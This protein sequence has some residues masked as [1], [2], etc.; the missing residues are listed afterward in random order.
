MFLSKQKQLLAI[1]NLIAGAISKWQLRKVTLL[2][3]GLFFFCISMIAQTTT[4][5]DFEYTFSGPNAIVKKYNGGGGVC[6]VPSEIT[7]NGLEYTV[8]KIGNRAFANATVTEIKLPETIE[9]IGVSSFTMCKS[10]TKINLPHG[11][12]EISGS[13]FWGC[14][15]LTQLIIPPSVNF[16][17]DSSSKSCFHNCLTL[18]TLI[19]LGTT[20]PQR[21]T[22]SGNTYVPDLSAYS[23]PYVTMNDARIIEMITFNENT[24]D[25]TG[26]A[27]KPTWTNN[28]AGWCANLDLSVIKADAGNYT[29]Y[30]PATFTKGTESFSTQIKYKYTINKGTITASVAN[31][32]RG[33]GDN[34]PTFNI[35]YSGFVNGDNESVITTKPIAITTATASSNVGTYPISVSGGVAQN[36][37]FKYELGT[38]TVTKAA[39]EISVNKVSKVYGSVN[40]TFTLNYSGLKNN[41]TSPS[42]E[43]SPTFSTT[44][45]NTSGVGDYPITVDCS[46]TN[47]NVTKNIPGTLTITPAILTV[48]ANNASRLYFDAEPEY[49][50][51]VT[52]FLNSDTEASFTKVPIF[53]TNATMASKVGTYTITPYGAESRNYDIKYE[54]GILTITKRQLTVTANVVSREYGENNPLFRISYDGFVNNENESMLDVIPSVT[55]TATPTSNVGTYT[56]SLSGGVATNYNLTLKSGILTVTKAPLAIVVNDATRKYGVF[57]PSFVATYSGLKNGETVPA[58]SVPPSFKTTA[59]IE[60]AVGTYPI[61]MVYGTPRNYEISEINKGTLSIIPADLT[62]KAK[63]ASKN[64]YEENPTFT[65]VCTGFVN[66]DN[67]SS[68]LQVQPTFTT[69]AN[70][71]SNVGTYEIVAK[72]ASSNNYNIVYTPGVLT[73]NKRQLVAKVG[74]FERNY[75][76]ENPSFTIEY[77]GFVGNDSERSLSIKPTAKT[78]ATSTSN[79]GTYPINVSGGEATNYKFSYT[80]GVLTVNKAEQSIDWNQDLSNVQVGSQIELTAVASSG[81]PI[82]YTMETNNSA[83]LYKVGTKTFIDCIASGQFLLKAIQNGNNNCYGTPKVTNTINIVGNTVADPTLTIIQGEKGLIKTQVAKGSVYTFTIEA[84]DGWKVHSVSFN[85]EDITEQLDA[86]NRFTTPKIN[87]STTLNVVYETSTDGICST[88]VSSAKILGTSYGI[89]VEN[90]KPN[91]VLKVYTI[92]GKL[93]KRQKLQSSE[94]DVD[95]PNNETYIINLED[96]RVKVRL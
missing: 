87:A 24:F 4:I 88:K 25:Y 59:T 93:V 39:L 8:T 82:E 32:S 92:D 31:V 58:W 63:D 21:W 49:T 62:I 15:N 69:T 51:A 10:M 77:E 67:A 83:S 28:V 91:E 71:K 53:K 50:Y 38:L 3:V 95:L 79:V 72:D 54:T 13:A 6:S 64:Y 41:E 14:Y 29:T 1:R 7:Y 96:I 33:Y 90:A 85:D 65:Y 37:T 89:K 9:Y 78:S 73:V 55:S 74:N 57:N 35:S 56:I 68:A 40:P 27:P 81:L 23:T 42:W 36:Y 11:L 45:D 86:H 22:A 5:G 94:V 61:E 75:G 66:G 20:A 44:A 18:R 84:T 76:E 19:Y 70:Q 60:S 26:T 2:F 30:I 52:G 34:N 43:K 16:A 80:N 48:K 12:K 47:Y 46:A 17:N